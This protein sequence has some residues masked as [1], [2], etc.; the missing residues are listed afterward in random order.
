MHVSSYG[1]R[2]KAV[3]SKV[4]IPESNTKEKRIKTSELQ[5]TEADW[6]QIF[7]ERGWKPA[8]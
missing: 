3:L 7:S 8:E 5:G 6:F 1:I 4:V 2:L